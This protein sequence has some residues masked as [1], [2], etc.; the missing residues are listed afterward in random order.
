LNNLRTLEPTVSPR[1]QT[2]P[3][4]TA[5]TS[6]LSEALASPCEIIGSEDTRPGSVTKIE[7]HAFNQCT[8]LTDVVVGNGLTNIGSCAFSGCTSLTSITIPGSVTDKGP[9]NHQKGAPLSVKGQ[10]QK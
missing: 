9:Q 1:A 8:K 7:D 6:A 5:A 3:A 2:Q 4:F 10:M